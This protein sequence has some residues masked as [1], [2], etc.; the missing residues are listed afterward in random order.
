MYLLVISNEKSSVHGH[1]SFQIN[2]CQF[3]L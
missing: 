1:E 3:I 2:S